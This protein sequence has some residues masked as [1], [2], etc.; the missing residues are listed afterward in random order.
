[1]EGNA[2][3]AL[4]MEVLVTFQL[5]FT[6]FSVEDQRT[7]EEGEPGNLAIGCSLSAGIFTAVSMC[8]YLQQHC[9]H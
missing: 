7:R 6:I 3:Q 8:L 1:M 2:G 4:G 9:H 5:V